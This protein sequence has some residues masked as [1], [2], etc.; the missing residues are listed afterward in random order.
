MGCG[1]GRRKAAARAALT[2]AREETETQAKNTPKV[3][4]G[5]RPAASP[6]AEP[7]K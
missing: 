5:V 2:A 7:A 1:C 6:T 3:W 4:T